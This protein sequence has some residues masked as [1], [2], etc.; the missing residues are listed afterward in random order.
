MA[1]FKDVKKPVLKVASSSGGEISPLRPAY[2]P[3][4]PPCAGGCP[5]GADIRGWL[6]TIAQAEAYGRTNEEAYRLAWER[7]TDRNPFPA[8]CGR[9]CP[10]LCEDACNRR[11]KDGA[12]AINALEQFVGDFG[13]A[14][15]LKLSRLTSEKRPE[16]IAVIGA[17][18][19]G[20]SC[21]YQLARRGY[22]VTIFEA[23]S[24]PGGML[25]YGI[26]KYRLPREVLDAEIQRI[27]DLGVSLQ[28]N[29]VIG[30]N[31]S[32][33]QLRGAYKAVF[34]G[35]GAHRGIALRIPG[36]DASN[37]YTG[38]EFLNR[39]NSAEEVRVGGTV[40]V[41]GGGDTA[42]DSARVSKRLGAHV[43]ILY[44]RSRSE[45]PAIKPEVD[46][47]LEE[48]VEI[49][50][51]TAPVEVL[52]ENGATVGLRCIRMDLGAPDASGRPRPV[53][54]PG[55]EFDLK[56]TTIIAAVSQQ[57]KLNGLDVVRN[58]GQWIP[59]QDAAVPGMEGVFAGGDGV[60][61][62]LVTIA[63]AQG[64]F[65]AEAI[66][67]WIQ[68]KTVERP[69]VAPCIGPE[70]VKLD[71]YKPAERHQ[72]AHVPVAA[73][74]A[75]TEIQVGLAEAEAL[76]EARRCMSCGMCMDCETCWMY[77]TNNCFAKLPKG[78]HYKVKL[79]LCN[80]CKKCADAC[81]CGYIEMN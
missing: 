1:L 37:V 50:Y 56:A 14:Q 77:C 78:E 10:H 6:T 41:I 21:A 79:E 11:K 66:D 54:I 24:E 30:S 70:R 5:S 42:I 64:R 63:V 15:G 45:M 28:C 67:A 75:G 8:V 2:L 22:A 3:K 59:T 23:F 29:A 31:L 73:R 40:L 53:A 80:G 55:S 4:A 39:V 52:R 35:I 47:A 72:R 20:L 33:D 60:E 71:W 34:V 44:R 26:P 36:E 17:G 16:S 81:P 32:L 18:P 49:R 19:A 7:I 38:T 61:L 74:S 69:A 9:V 12:V 58:G 57:P 76:D 43:T 25:R 46:G 68:G 62:G 13:I 51:L 48:G 27:L 65:A